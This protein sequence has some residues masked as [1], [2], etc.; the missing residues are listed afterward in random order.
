MG[1]VANMISFNRGESVVP[2]KILLLR[3]KFLT[4]PVQDCTVQ[5]VYSTLLLM[6]SILDT[7]ITN[8]TSFE[9]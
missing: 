8:P 3:H 9:V 6:Y 5:Y 2:C 1:P 4:V 7:G